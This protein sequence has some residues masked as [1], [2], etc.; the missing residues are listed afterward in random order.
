MIFT[1][2]LAL[3]ISSNVSPYRVELFRADNFGQDS[4]VIDMDTL[5]RCYNIEACSMQN[6]ASSAKFGQKGQ[7]V[8]YCFYDNFDCSGRAKC[9]YN[10]QT[11][12]NDFPHDGIND[13]VSAVAVVAPSDDNCHNNMLFQAGGLRDIWN[14]CSSDS[15]FQKTF[16]RNAIVTKN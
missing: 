1:T 12:P 13:M 15:G 14:V 2:L 9:W 11:D 10:T 4:L 16:L 5:N 3:L 7:R 8:C 6:Q